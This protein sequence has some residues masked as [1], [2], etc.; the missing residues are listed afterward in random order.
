MN[1]AAQQPR[2]DSA[3]KN[4]VKA[5]NVFPIRADSDN[6]PLAHFKGEDE[7]AAPPP[8]K[9]PPVRRVPPKRVLTGVIA[10]AV[11]VGIAA[12]AL[13]YA[14][15]RVNLAV[16][17]AKPA[18]SERA[19][20]NSRPEGAAVTV[21]GVARGV[22]PIELALAA[23]PHD[24]VLRNDA[25]ERRLIVTV[26]KGTVVSEN[27]DMPA[28]VA[29]GQLD[30][31]S[32]PSGARVTVDGATA[33]RTPLK[34][35]S[36]SP[37]RHTVVVSE[38]TSA[39]NRSVDVSAGATMSM[40]ISLATTQAVGSTGTVAFDS[41]LELRLLEDG[42]LLGLSN[43]S[44]LVLGPGKHKLDLVN[45]ALE[46]QLSRTVTIEAG[47]T[48][49]VSVPAPNGTVNVN[50]TP[51]ADVS[52]DGRSIGTTP[53]GNVSV[54]VGTHEIVWRHPQLGEKRKTVVVGAQSPVRLTMDMGR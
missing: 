18:A 15:Q 41:P 11:V 31:T 1:K 51:W 3:D 24:V 48:T 49:R 39:V 44:P 32:D 25:G 26:E 21:D 34:V 7:A 50:A 53:L 19:R 37:G 10:A 43:G 46:M 40:F 23:G 8:P 5:Q 12:A 52:V 22:T 4:D 54:A 28:A 9:P 45:D 17:A 42:H 14:R 30:V 27:V 38:G 33:G 47:K 16:P 36:L 13:V 6:D 35:R 20:L 2:K 29:S